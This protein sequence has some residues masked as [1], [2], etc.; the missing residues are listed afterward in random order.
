MAATSGKG[1]REKGAAA[2]RELA[3]KLSEKLGIPIRRGQVFNGE[4]DLVGVPGIHPEVKR[5]E[6]LNIWAAFR[7]AVEAARKRRD[8]LPV[9]FFRKNNET[10]KVLMDLDDWISFYR[11]WRK[12]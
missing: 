12:E 2:E 9:V 4:A 7:Q 8:G 1:S 6:R 11:A 10:W 5:V 3:R